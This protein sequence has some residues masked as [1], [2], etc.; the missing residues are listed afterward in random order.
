MR[1][2]WMTGFAF[3]FAISASPILTCQ[4][5]FAGPTPPL[6]QGDGQSTTAPHSENAG[7]LRQNNI[8]A[9]GATVPRPGVSQGPGP[10]PLDHDIERLN[11]RIQN[12]I[13]KGC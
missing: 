13:C 12:S 2:L 4:N 9:T 5:A 7:L 3:A 1:K 8:T 11:D 10:T 6:S